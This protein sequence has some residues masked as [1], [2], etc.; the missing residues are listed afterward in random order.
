MPGIHASGVSGNQAV[1]HICPNASPEEIKFGRGLI[2]AAQSAGVGHIVY[3][4]VL[5]PQIEAM[6]HHWHKLRVEEMIFESGI[7]FTIL[8]PAAYMQNILAHWQAIVK[9]GRYP[10][11]YSAD[12][13]LSYVDLEDLAEVAAI[14]LTEPGH[15]GAVY[16]LSGAEDLS[17]IEICEILSSCLGHR[18]C[19]QVIPVEQWQSN[20]RSQGLGEYQVNALVKMFRYYEQHGFIGNSRILECLLQRPATNFASFVARTI[21]ERPHEQ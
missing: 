17:Q 16:E 2:E 4:S 5:H 13:R 20:A 19:V 14:V 9:Q 18:V 10:V 8:Q 15:K 12:T 11:P 1:Y 3:H 6:P 21:R 7:P